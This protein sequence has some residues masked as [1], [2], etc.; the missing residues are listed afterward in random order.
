MWILQGNEKTQEQLDAYKRRLLFVKDSPIK[1]ITLASVLWRMIVKREHTYY[2]TA[3]GQQSH[4][5]DGHRA[6]SVEDMYSVAKNYVKKEVT[7]EDVEKAIEKLIKANLIT[8]SF[9]STINR[10][11]HNT[12]SLTTKLAEFK[13]AMK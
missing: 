5:C 7:R 1:I 4:Q 8:Q 3:P 9:C 2:E 10:R 13:K 12:R 6:R 11:V